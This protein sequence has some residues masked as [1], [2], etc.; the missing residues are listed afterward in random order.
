MGPLYLLS[1]GSK[2][3]KDNHRLVVEMADEVLFRVPLREISSIVVSPA[4]R[5]AQSVLFACLRER[6]LVFFINGRCELLG[7][8]APESAPL[9]MLRHQMAYVE[10]AALSLFLAKMVV[11][12]KIDNQ[13]HLLKSYAKTVQQEDLRQALP[14]LRALRKKVDSVPSCTALRGL[15]GAAARAYFSAFAALLDPRLWQFPRRS[16]HPAKDA[17]NALLN[18]GYAFLEREVRSAIVALHLDPRLGFLHTSNGRKDSLVFDLMELFRQS[19]IDR[20]VLRLLRLK[21]LKPV[22]FSM[23]DAGG[24]YLSDSARDTWIHRYEAYMTKPYQHYSGKSPRD[25]IRSR[26]ADFVHMLYQQT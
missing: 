5:I 11:K 15:E 16:R 2:L 8:L 18:L 21:M 6:I 19:V 20:F 25:Y 3:R 7:T 13:Y 22:D 23:D 10:D 4:A 14:L 26:L 17:P 24:F 12:E 1:S 9:G